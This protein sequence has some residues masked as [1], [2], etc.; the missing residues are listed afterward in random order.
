MSNKFEGHFAHFV[1]KKQVLADLARDIRRLRVAFAY[2]ADATHQQ[3]SRFNDIRVGQ[4]RRDL[5]AA[6]T[7][8]TTE[9]TP[10]NKGIDQKQI[11][12]N[13]LLRDTRRARS[14]ISWISDNGGLSMLPAYQRNYPILLET[15]A[16][17]ARKSTVEHAPETNLALTL[18]YAN[19]LT[20]SAHPKLNT[21]KA[22]RLAAMP[23][24]LSHLRNV[25]ASSSY[26]PEH[27]QK[28]EDDLYLQVQQANQFGI[29]VGLPEFKR[30]EVESF[31]LALKSPN[32]S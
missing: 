21:G 19:L 18:G 3:L 4:T 27:R 23:A 16:I 14:F 31:M 1:E 20:I 32:H 10:T 30:G 24:Y 15:L 26:Y 9:Y 12:E 5:C 25:W 8:L 6:L 11:E 2:Y 7:S 29:G 22:D 13:T 17:A 28:M